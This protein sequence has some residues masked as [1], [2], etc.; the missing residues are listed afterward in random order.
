MKIGFISH[1]YD[2][3]GGAAA[4]PGTVAR[5]LRDLGHEVH[6]VTGF[7]T[8]PHGRVFDGYH[9]RPYV[10]E[11]L[12]GVTVHRSPIYPSHDTRAAHRAAN[13]L[14]FVATGAPAALRVLRSC[15]VAYVYSTPATVGAIGRTLKAVHGVPYVL[16]IQDLWP[17]TVTSSG[18]IEGGAAGRVEKSL[19]RF[20]DWV[21]AAAARIAVISPGMVDLV[22]ARGVPRERLNVVPNWADESAFYPAPATPEILAEFGAPRECT[23]M[24][25]GNFGEMQQLDK[26]IDAASELAGDSRIGI[27]LVGAGVMED[28]LRAQV[29]ARRLHNVRFLGQ[30]PFSRMSEILAVGDVQLVSLKDVPLYR[31]TIPSKLQANMAAG[32]ALLGAIAGDGAEAIVASGGGIA[33]PPG[34]VSALVAAMRTMTDLSAEQR[35]ELGSLARAFYTQ[36]YSQAAVS[37]QLSDLLVAA[38]GERN[39]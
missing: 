21:Y 14:S 13:Y 37:A 6:V 18:F 29:A 32:K 20:C 39:G 5:A 26:V 30:Q 31:V 17:Q 19:H 36:H 34:D 27:A 2:P 24:Y 16:H 15:D 1:W 7:P 35:L 9:Q 11:V 8:Y 10:R 12:D 4:G 28:R 33:V 22:A 38:A 3:E 25:A 23:F